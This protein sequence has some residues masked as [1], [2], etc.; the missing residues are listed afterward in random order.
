[1]KAKLLIITPV[2]DSMDTF[3]RTARSVMSTEYDGKW[4]YVVYDDFSSPESVARLDA[5]ALELGFELVHLANVIDTPSPNYRY[6]L[7]VAQRRALESDAHLVIVESDVVVEADTMDKLEAEATDVCGM[8][9][10]VTVDDN[11]EVNF[12][13]LYARKFRNELVPTRKRFSFCCT[14]L[15]NCFLSAFDF[16]ELDPTKSWY[17]V[18]ISHRSV[19]S[20]FVNYLDMRNRVRHYPHSSRPWKLL[21]YTNPLKYYWIKYTKGLDKI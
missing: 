6:V 8:V 15:T 2:K 4:Q 11:N 21:K 14:L 16:Q 12:P 10:A 19:K 13:Y 20:G 18:T 9:A 7:Q 5:L 1:M 3:E 17:D